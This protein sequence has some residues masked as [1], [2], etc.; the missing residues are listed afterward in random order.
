MASFIG[1]DKGGKSD[2]NPVTTSLPIS[3]KE[4]AFVCFQ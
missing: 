1:T 3:D 2:P 4:G